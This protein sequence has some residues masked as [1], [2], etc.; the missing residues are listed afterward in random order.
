M[1]HSTI[2]S[3]SIPVFSEI[4]AE[5]PE[6]GRIFST[7]T[8]NTAGALV[9]SAKTTVTSIVRC[10]GIGNGRD[11]YMN[12][13]NVIDTLWQSGQTNL[14]FSWPWNNSTIRERLRLRWMT[15]L[16]SARTSSDFPADSGASV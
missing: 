3:A 12:G 13:S 11:K 14:D 4:A 10:V 7:S 2:R 15:Q 16:S 1:S 8:I 6:I 5:I 9:A